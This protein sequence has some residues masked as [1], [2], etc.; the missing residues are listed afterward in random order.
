[1]SVQLTDSLHDALLKAPEVPAATAAP[2]PVLDDSSVSRAA[3]DTRLAKTYAE[4]LTTGARLRVPQDS[5]LGRWIE[6]LKSAFASPVL[7]RM[8]ASGDVTAI[9]VDPAKGEI[10]VNYRGGL[11]RES[12][13]L[14]EIPG[15]LD[16]FDSL[17]TAAKA[18]TPNGIL[19]LPNYFQDGTVALGDVQRFYGEPAHLTPPQQIARSKELTRHPVFQGVGSL[20]DNDMRLDVLRGIGNAQTWHNL[21]VVLKEQVEKPGA[22]LD[23]GAVE[24]NVAPHSESWSEQQQQPVTQ[25]LKQLLIDQGLNVPVTRDEL[26]NLER[27]LSAPPLRAPSEGDYGGLL[28]KDM[29]L[30]ESDQKK[31]TQTVNT[32]KASQTQVTADGQGR[33]P[34][35]LDYLQRAVPAHVRAKAGEAPEAFLH[36]LI[37]TPQ[38][39]A[40]GKQLQEA[41]DAPATATGAQEVLLT[42]LGLEAD[43]A[44]GR[45]RNNLAGYDL[46]QQDNWGQS[47]AEIVKRFEN[48]LESRFGPQLAKVAAYQLLA[49][50]APDFLVKELPSSMVYG[51]Q[52]WASFSAAVLRRELDTPGSSAG[53]TYAHIMQHDALDP[54]TEAGQS[55]SQFA[56][57]QSVIDW[58]IANGVVEARSDDAYSAE[59]IDRAVTALQTQVDGLVS[60]ANSLAA[61]MPTRR[62]LA[63]AEL[64]RVYGDKME[65]FFEDKTLLGDLPLGS[66]KRGTYSLLNIYMS[67]DLHKHAWTSSDKDFPTAIVQAGFSKL[68]DIKATFEERFNAYVDD[69]KNASAT[70][71]NYQVSQLPAEDRKMIEYGKVTTF[72]LG[73]PGNHARGSIRTDHPMFNYVNSGAVLVRA[74]LDGKTCH[75][76]YSPSQG[77]IIKDADPSRPGLQSPSSRLYFSMARPGRP[78]EREDTV[79]ILWQTPLTPWP[80]KDKID[81]AAF[82]IYPSKS[83]ASQL[84]G[85]HSVPHTG[86]PSARSNELGS[87]V[88]AYYTRAVQD[89]RAA[90]KGES[91][92]ERDERRN[93]ADK[94]FMLGLIPFYDA[95]KSFTK[96]DVLTGLLYAVL[97]V[98]GLV[99]PAVKGGSQAI[100]AGSKGLGAALSFLKGFTKAGVKAA[101]PLGGVYDIGRGVFTLGKRGIK[102]LSRTK[103]PLV[104]KLRHGRGRSGSFDIPQGVKKTPVANGVYRPLGENTDALPALAVRRNGKWYAFD[105]KTQVPYGAPLKGFTPSAG[106]AGQR[107]ASIAVGVATDTAVGVG[108]GLV[109]QKIRPGGVPRQFQLPSALAQAEVERQSNA[110]A[111]QRVAD[112]ALPARAQALHLELRQ[113]NKALAALEGVAVQDVDTAPEISVTDILQRLDQMEAELDDLEERTDESA[114]TFRV[115]FQRYLPAPVNAQDKTAVRDRLTATE[116]RLAAVKKA[117]RDMQAQSSKAA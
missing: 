74:E 36:A 51:S 33:A 110:E 109:V 5:T 30:G 72:S 1:M 31:I 70:F 87:V 64:R 95:I 10:R 112:Q 23:V 85:P 114:P 38:A 6:A 101:N 43:P 116:K 47:P 14:A 8:L 94:Q 89:Q 91:L 29:P 45:Q 69:L 82:S 84:P 22:S 100:K 39:R 81:F 58:G 57:M 25:S 80:K 34:S 111:A 88:G 18:L 32:W 35:L 73:V 103:F 42:A 105:P 59:T 52:Q 108:A 4:Q 40:L 106:S 92:Q 37:N 2:L 104:D 28:S 50:S 86:L 99:V 98:I 117:V 55:Q 65:R 93:K 75:Y 90:A 13:S 26:A 66:R 7:Q 115:F 79:T 107:S 15:G 24:V 17:M 78:G 46:R 83:L 71:F 68:P 113:A 60:A 41:I 63:L 48:H 44:G 9:E 97:D 49:L 12:V 62:E 56:A 77:K 102:S 67:G 53:Q 76:L 19:S 20:P 61:P 16:L 11:I 96:G 27:S 3:G 21:L 54:V